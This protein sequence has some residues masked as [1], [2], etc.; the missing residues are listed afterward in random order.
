MAVQEQGGNYV[1]TV[2]VD[3]DFP[4]NDSFNSARDEAGLEARSA[5]ARHHKTVTDANPDDSVTMGSLSY[6]ADSGTPPDEAKANGYYIAT[7]TVP[8]SSVKTDDAPEAPAASPTEEVKTDKDAEE[9]EGFWDKAKNAFGFDEPEETADEKKAK[10]DED[11]CSDENRP[12]GEDRET[13]VERE[14]KEAENRDATPGNQPHSTAKEEQIADEEKEA[15]Q[16]HAL[17]QQGFLMRGLG[18]PGLIPPA[19]AHR[20]KGMAGS[21]YRSISAIHTDG[22]TTNPLQIKNLLTAKTYA[23]HFLTLTNTQLSALVPRIRL[24]RINYKLENPTNPPVVDPNNPETEFYFH[25]HYD[26]NGI[27]SLTMGR[28]G[29]GAGVGIKEF[30]WS[31]KATSPGDKGKRFESVLKLHFQSLDDL[32]SSQDARA[33]NA[34]E[35][36]PSFLNLIV[37]PHYQATETNADGKKVMSSDKYNPEFFQIRATVGWGIPNQAI[38]DSLGFTME[39]IQ[40]VQDSQETFFLQLNRH[41]FDFAE[42]GSIEMTVEYYATQE[43]M[44]DSGALDLFYVSDSQVQ[45]KLDAGVIESFKGKN[46]NYGELEKRRNDAEADGKHGKAHKIK[47]EMNDL[48]AKARKVLV[49]EQHNSLIET[50]AKDNAVRSMKVKASAV[51]MFKMDTPGF[52]GLRWV[53]RTMKGS[54]EDMIN[55]FKGKGKEDLVCSE[56]AGTVP[57]ESAGFDNLTAD[58]EKIADE[59]KDNV[60]EFLDDFEL[61]PKANKDCVNLR[62]FFLGDLIDAACNILLGGGASEKYKKSMFYGKFSVILGPITYTNPFRTE[63]ING[64]EVM[65]KESLSLADVPVSFDLFRIWW[66]KTV[67]EPGLPAMTLKQFVEGVVGQLITPAIGPDAFGEAG[68]ANVGAARGTPSIT[69]FNFP[70]PGGESKIPLGK[71]VPVSDLRTMFGTGGGHPS[72]SNQFYSVVDSY[73]YLYI[74]FISRDV[75]S[76]KGCYQEDLDNGIYHLALGRDRGVIKTIKFK[77]S[78]FPGVKEHAMTRDESLGY[79]N[80]RE[81]YDADVTMIGSTLFQNGDLVFLNPLTVGSGANPGGMA[82]RTD[83]MSR[84]LIGGYY[85]VIN[86]DN[87]V[88]ADGFETSFSSKRLGKYDHKAGC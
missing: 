86:V 84:L 53:Q 19:D 82:D 67:I 49:A 62:Y 15:A 34:E 24:W 51:G 65:A 1:V 3:V 9:K 21:F 20:A 78:D 4:D 14:Q 41:S 88:S 80:L 25:S 69:L 36:P 30:T 47:G 26:S 46:E 22:D 23:Q 44:L 16:M 75:S 40:A 42:D 68:K 60:M 43:G 50:L 6:V 10:A 39:Q 77:R 13:C 8:I 45:E 17:H 31:D 38:A 61:E 81:P 7:Y 71:K 76:L 64:E 18:M 72:D 59:K 79:E 11:P 73:Y 52:G 87:T 37:P 28:Y 5:I 33:G 57:Q 27:G 74:C 54:A 58:T 48:Q 29:R 83:V 35:D 63:T 2:N 32:I 55:A 12:K 85:V 70:S 66:M 56:G